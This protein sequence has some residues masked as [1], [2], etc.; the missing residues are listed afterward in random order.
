MKHSFFLTVGPRLFRIGSDWRSPIAALGTL[1]AAYPQ[2]AGIAD[3]TV[4]L[5]A[6]RWWRRFIRPQLAI[7]GDHRLPDALPVRLDHG[8]LAGEMAMNLQMALGERRFLL[9]HAATVE[10]GGRAL[11]LTGESGSGKSTLAAVLALRGWR[12]MG[13]EFALLDPATGQL[14]PFPRPVS[15]KG[16]SI[17]LLQGLAPG[18]TMGPLQRAT[19]KGDLRHMVPPETAI[20]RMD[21]PAAPAL[22]LFPRFGFASE[23]RP[24]A[25]GEC[26]VRLTQAS[27][28]YTALGEPGFTAL[29][30]L[31]RE[32]PAWAIDY[33]D[34]EAACRQIEALW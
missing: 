2:A 11:I 15:L 26:F 21:D 8:V 34:A 30:T 18:A 6:T 3:Y 22:I 28:N 25:P 10:R 13:D 5:E 17:A 7:A 1:Y 32:T 23:T 24:V 20:D 27:T 33:P 14:R 16:E 12:F 29:A 19:A 31:V 9:L 4:R